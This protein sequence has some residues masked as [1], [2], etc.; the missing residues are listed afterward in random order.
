MYT[1]DIRTRITNYDRNRENDKIVSMKMKMK[2]L[3]K[4]L[5]ASGQYKRNNDNNNV[6]DDQIKYFNITDNNN[7]HQQQ[8]RMS[9]TMLRNDSL[10]PMRG[11]ISSRS[12]SPS[13]LSVTNYDGIDEAHYRYKQ[14]NF[15]LY[16][17]VLYILLLLLFLLLSSLLLS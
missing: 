10:S 6:V 9:R 14:S 2:E 17:Y 16:R 3:K 4:R 7:N 15:L 11:T 8:H 1:N 13:K 12:P 5:K